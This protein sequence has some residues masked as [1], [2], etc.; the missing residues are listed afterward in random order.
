MVSSN[1]IARDY[2]GSPKPAAAG[3]QRNTRTNVARNGRS[4][5]S[6][7]RREAAGA[8]AGRPSLERLFDIGPGFISGAQGPCLAISVDRNILSGRSNPQRAPA[9]RSQTGT[10]DASAMRGTAA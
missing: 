1:S 7:D 8:G 6:N 9:Q 5:T 4:H 3:A 10:K 2:N